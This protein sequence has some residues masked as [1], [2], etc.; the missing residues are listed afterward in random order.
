MSIW[1]EI[2]KSVNSELDIP[3]N[4]MLLS[5]QCLVSTVIVQDDNGKNV[6]QN[7]TDDIAGSPITI[8]K[9]SSFSFQFYGLGSA[10]FYVDTSNFVVSHDVDK[11]ILYKNEKEEE[12][13]NRN[14]SD[15]TPLPFN[16]SDIFKV[17]NESPFYDVILH[18]YGK[19]QNLLGV[20]SA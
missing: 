14:S 5:T 9:S 12:T 19:T 11:V 20:V 17:V 7:I 6:G 1:K 4:E 16:S 10:S 15:K 8:P 2:K 3:L 18:I 13:W